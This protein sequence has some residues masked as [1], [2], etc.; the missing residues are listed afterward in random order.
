MIYGSDYGLKGHLVSSCPFF[1]R[2]TDTE[3]FG[4]GKVGGWGGR[5]V[6]PGASLSYWLD[7]IQ[8]SKYEQHRIRGNTEPEIHILHILESFI[9][10]WGKS[11]NFCSPYSYRFESI[12]F[13]W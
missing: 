9:G 6:D 2:F 12:I 3:W 7:H 11:F 8:I 1:S 10:I 13:R 4:E 5:A